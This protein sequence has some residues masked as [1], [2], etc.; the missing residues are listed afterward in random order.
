MTPHLY[1]LLAQTA[2]PDGEAKAPGDFGNKLSD[3]IGYGK[4]V[5]LAICVLALIA[6]AVKMAIDNQRGHG[7]DGPGGIV[8]VLGAVAIISGAASLVGLFV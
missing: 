5:A 4:Y 3:M 1:A 7:G 6:A 2:V 8:K